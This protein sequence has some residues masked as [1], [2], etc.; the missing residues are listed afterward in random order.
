MSKVLVVVDAQNDF[1]TGSLRNEEAI[2]SLD[3]LHNVVEY[4]ENSGA[5]LIYTM[6]T[7]YSNY[8]ETQEGTRLPVEHCRINTDGWDIAP[9]ARPQNFDG[10]DIIEKDTFGF[11]HWEEYRLKKAEEIVLVGY[12]SSICVV[13]NALILKSIY[14]EVSITFITDASAGL[15]PENHQAAIEVLKSCQINCVTWKEYLEKN[16]K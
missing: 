8:F 10:V 12:V 9:A 15:T 14:P 1:I 13:S 3:T 7:H 4:M 6:D 2:Q 16:G 11:L 5:R